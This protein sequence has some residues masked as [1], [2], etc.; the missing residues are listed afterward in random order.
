MRILLVA[1]AAVLLSGC[2]VLDWGGENVD[3][4]ELAVKAGTLRYIESDAEDRGARAAAVVD[5]IERVRK[6]VD[7]EAEATV[8]EIEDRVREEIAW[9]ELELSE[10]LVVDRLVSRVRGEMQARVES[11]EGISDEDRVRV[12]SVLDWAA[13]A[14]AMYQ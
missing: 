9:D 1:L 14:A 8:E 2:A 5:V 11:A 6:Q 3:T 4:A 12:L 13:D 7:S 10:Q